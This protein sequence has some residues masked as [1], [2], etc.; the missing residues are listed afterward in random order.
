MQ[1]YYTIVPIAGPRR[2]LNTTT[3]DGYTIPK[4]STILIAL[5]DLHFNKDFW[6]NPKTFKPERF[7][8]DDGTV[9]SFENF[10]PFGNGNFIN[11]VFTNR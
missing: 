6:E 1:R 10:Y 11:I 2:V 7:L 3:I 5:G 9:K 8:N 4:E